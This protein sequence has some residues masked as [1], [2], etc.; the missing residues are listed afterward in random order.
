MFVTE[1]LNYRQLIYNNYFSTQVNKSRS[2]I[3]PLLE[4]QVRHNTDELAR[5]LPTD[6]SS[7]I[8]DLGCGFGGMVEAANRLGY[9]N[10]SGYDISAEQVATAH[11]LGINNVQELSIDDFFTRNETVDMI[12]GLDIIEHFTKDELVAFLTNI[13]SCLNPNGVVLFRTPN[14]DASQTSVYSYGDISHEVY[15]NKS[16]ATQLMS[17]CGYKNIAVFGGLVKNPNPFKNAL[18]SVL[19]STI[20]TYKKLELFATAR[21]WHNVVFEPNLLIKASI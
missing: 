5:Y 2:E 10:V 3:R 7:R 13:K 21:T 4:E 18:R 8:V 19:W 15:L 6:K 12:I 14:M 20:K 1:M 16:S 11:A 17:S 9:N